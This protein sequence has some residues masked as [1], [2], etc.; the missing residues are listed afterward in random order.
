MKEHGQEHVT[1]RDQE[2]EEVL[3]ELNTKMEDIKSNTMPSARERS[4]LASNIPD[5]MAKELNAE[6]C[7]EASALKYTSVKSEE[8]SDILC[9][10]GKIFTQYLNFHKLHANEEFIICSTCGIEINK[11]GE[12]KHNRQNHK[13]KMRKKCEYKECIY[14]CV[15]YGILRR[16]VNKVHLNL[17]RLKDIICDDCGKAFLQQWHLKD[18]IKIEHHGEK[19]FKCDECGKT[20]GR[21]KHLW[22]HSQVHMVFWAASQFYVEM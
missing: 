5:G 18:H 16:H 21:K 11:K 4:E 22:A 1:E 2:L 6:T 20:F 17:P 15:T 12:G 3:E 7:S 13:D 19:D 10:C 8:R 14:T 9:K